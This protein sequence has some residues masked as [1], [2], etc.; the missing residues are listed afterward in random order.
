VKPENLQTETYIFFSGALKAACKSDLVPT[1]LWAHDIPIIKWLI[2]L[3]EITFY[4]QQHTKCS[5]W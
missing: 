1:Y 4:S 5:L 3:E 2:L